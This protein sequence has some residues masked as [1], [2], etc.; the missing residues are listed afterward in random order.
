MLCILVLSHYDVVEC[1]VIYVTKFSHCYHLF[2]YN[3]RGVGNCETKLPLS[4]CN[5]LTPTRWIL[6]KFNAEICNKIWPIRNKIWPIQL[7]FSPIIF[8]WQSTRN[9]RQPVRATYHPNR[10][11][12]CS[13]SF[14]N[15]LE[16]K[17]HQDIHH[18][19]R[20]FVCKLC[21]KIFIRKGLLHLHLRL[22]SE[23]RPFICDA[24]TRKFVRKDGVKTHVP[25]P[26]VQQS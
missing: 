9:E 20:P 11:D 12:L 5:N 7:C 26:G 19:Q 24:C 6:T 1:K 16:L 23:D 25:T 15:Q 17:K 3:F 2:M 10:C 8:F 21:H 4:T 22:R 18:A 13:T 14:R